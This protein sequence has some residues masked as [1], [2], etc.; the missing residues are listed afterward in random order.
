MLLFMVG[1]S[2]KMNVV[3]TYEFVSG[4]DHTMPKEQVVTIRVVYIQR[5]K[6][7]EIARQVFERDG[8]PFNPPYTYVGFFDYTTR[9]LY[10]EKWDAVICGHELFH[11]TDG[12]WHY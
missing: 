12:D 6:I 8:L 11:A 9:T 3:R 1:C 2:Y 10:C 4:A 5:D 7:H